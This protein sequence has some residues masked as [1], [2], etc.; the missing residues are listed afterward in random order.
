MSKIRNAQQAVDKASSLLALDE[1]ETL[2]EVNNI[3]R[4]LMAQL[5]IIEL[6]QMNYTHF[7]IA[8]EVG[9][10][11]KTIRMWLSADHSPTLEHLIKLAKFYR[12]VKGSP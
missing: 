9:V 6:Y 12:K 3:A 5:Q 11:E 4:I 7:D 1:Y 2:D 8:R 10:N